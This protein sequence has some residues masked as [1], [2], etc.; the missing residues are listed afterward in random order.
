V[1]ARKPSVQRAKREAYVRAGT[2]SNCGCAMVRTVDRLCRKCGPEIRE[3][4]LA[5]SAK[6]LE[7][8]RA[9]KYFRYY[10]VLHKKDPSDIGRLCQFLLLK[11]QQPLWRLSGLEAIA[12]ATSE[13]EVNIKALEAAWGESEAERRF[14]TQKPH[15][16]T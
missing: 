14:L 1:T 6:K 4:Q 13:D 15:E 2:C 12:N 8:W 9:T 3:E 5:D 16:V 10:V 11:K 7:D